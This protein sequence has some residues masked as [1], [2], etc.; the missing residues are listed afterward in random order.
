[1]NTGRSNCCGIEPKEVVQDLAAYRSL[2]SCR[3]H[4]TAADWPTR[5]LVW[6]RIDSVV[7]FGLRPMLPRRYR[8]EPPTLLIQ[9]TTQTQ[10]N[11]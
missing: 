9:L 5:N 1:M 4:Y 3:R 10:Q 7:R 2:S 6:H 11:A 8:L